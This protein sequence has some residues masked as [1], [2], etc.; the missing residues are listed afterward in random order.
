MY[1]GDCSEGKRVI[2]AVDAAG[3][4][5]RV[6]VHKNGQIDG[7]L[8]EDAS[9][10]EEQASVLRSSLQLLRQFCTEHH[11]DIVK[12]FFVVFVFVCPLES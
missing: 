3:V 9:V 4:C 10:P 6:I 7:F 2:F 8:D 12:D 5:P 11:R 1:L